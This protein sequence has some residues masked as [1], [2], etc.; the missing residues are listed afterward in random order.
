MA[1][2]A[3]DFRDALRSILRFRLASTAIVL[4][5]LLGFAASA[6]SFA[7]VNGSLLAPIELPNEGRVV[8]VEEIDPETPEPLPVS[9]FGYGRI[10]DSHTFESTA[11]IDYGSAVYRSSAAPPTRLASLRTTPNLLRILGLRPR[12]GRTLSL[13]SY[14]VL[15]HED[16]AKR[17]F[18]GMGEAL[19]RL[20]E[21]DGRQHVVVGVFP[22]HLDRLNTHID[23]L[24]PLKLSPNEWSSTHTRFLQVIALLPKGIRVSDAEERLRHLAPT[25][26]APTAAAQNGESFRLRGLLAK[27]YQERAGSLPLQLATSVLVFLLCLLNTVMLLLVMIRS[28]AKGLAIRAACGATRL[29]I[30]RLQATRA[31]L[32]VSGSG[33]AA[34]FLTLASLQYMQRNPLIPAWETVC[35]DGNVGAFLLS[36]TALALM[37][38]WLLIVCSAASLHPLHSLRPSTRG[39]HRSR[40]SGWSLFVSC[41]TA[42]AVVLATLSGLAVGSL[43]RINSVDRGFVVDHQMVAIV[44]LPGDRYGPSHVNR[45]RD[46]WRRLL[47][48]VE[49]EPGVGRASA[50][51]EVPLLGD[52]ALSFPVRI[53]GDP[54]KEALEARLNSVSSGYLQVF[55]FR[56]VS[57]RGF[58]EREDGKTAPVAIVNESFARNQF[59]GQDAVGRRIQLLK[60]RTIVGVVA[61]VR[62]EGLVS[63][64]EPEIWI[65]YLQ[66][67]HSAA[68]CLSIRGSVS[69]E[70]IRNA[71]AHLD[72]NLP[73]TQITTMEA[74]LRAQ[75]QSWRH[76]ATLLSGFGLISLALAMAGAYGVCLLN[77]RRQTRDFAVRVALGA[78]SK[79]ILFRV[80]T[81]SMTPALL[82]VLVGLLSTIGAS[83]LVSSILFGVSATDP[84]TLGLVSLLVLFSALAASIMPAIAA[85]KSDPMRILRL[86]D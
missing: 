8:V 66:S 35:F 76:N 30:V 65:P 39:K 20:V 67:P 83:G 48:S 49:A 54:G 71:V 41:Q 63:A 47:E 42:T 79:R 3:R 82:G 19:G 74:L 50:S 34:A 78:D 10:R 84:S 38:C 32:L 37:S 16:F 14:E 27:F 43:V 51:L 13:N 40:E 53:V 59:P 55:G 85:S 58:R 69:G 29:E 11:A 17:H 7:I 12:V 80:L 75:T 18:A 31:L 86:S 21:L 46:F 2:L 6:I 56:L 45:E 22:R 52:G 44:D 70:S 57:G 72:S 4:L 68:R 77:S 64:P 33:I 60:Q 26:A 61:D 73:V 81:Q 36:G 28:D 62:T 9:P 25:G 24:V 5:L 15:I 23:I 1:H